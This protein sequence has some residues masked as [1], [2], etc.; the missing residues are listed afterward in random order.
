M[1]ARTRA[2]RCCQRGAALSHG[3]PPRRSGHARPW[4]RPGRSQDRHQHSSEQQ[5]VT[6]GARLLHDEAYLTSDATLYGLTTG[7]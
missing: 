7:R 2:S 6:G 1:A 4:R 5:A 3:R